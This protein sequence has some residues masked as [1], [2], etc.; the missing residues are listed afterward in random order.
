MRRKNL[1]AYCS[2]LERMLMEMVFPKMPSTPT[3]FRSTPGRERD[4]VSNRYRLAHL[5]GFLRNNVDLTYDP[6][7]YSN[8][9]ALTHGMVTHLVP[10]TPRLVDIPGTPG[11]PG[12]PPP[13][14]DTP[15]PLR[16]GHSFCPGTETLDIR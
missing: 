1:T 12:T 5:R 10:R 15:P 3:Q 11:T 4:R 16:P 13:G 9:T 14:A 2:Y 7:Y 8:T 6:W